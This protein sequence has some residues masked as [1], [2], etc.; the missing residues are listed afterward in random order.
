MHLDLFVSAEGLLAEE[1]NDV[2]ER[3]SL[4]WKMISQQLEDL[5]RKIQL[6]EDINAYFRQL[7]ALEKT[8]TAKEE[9]LR[10]V[11]FSE[12]PQRSLPSL[13]DSCQVGR[14]MVGLWDYRAF[15]G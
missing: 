9:W 3:V 12:S 8:V 5:G 6:Q 15:V 2:L 11:S 14:E 13:K 10:D 7:D 4:E 1:I